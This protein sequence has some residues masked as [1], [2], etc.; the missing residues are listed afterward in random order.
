MKRCILII[1]L[2]FF[3][4]LP[5]E[6]FAKEKKERPEF[7]N[8]LEPKKVDEILDIAAKEVKK[9][10]PGIKEYYDEY[11]KSL[12]KFAREMGEVFRDFF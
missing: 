11:M 2:T 8:P 12:N 7:N 10:A 3:I 1:V 6:S 4:T 5:A 9:Q